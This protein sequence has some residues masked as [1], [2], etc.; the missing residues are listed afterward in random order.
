LK[1][2]YSNLNS[3]ELSA[4]SFIVVGIVLLGT[5]IFSSLDYKQ[6][7]IVARGFE[8]LDMGEEATATTETVKFVVNI[9]HEF[10]DQFYVAFTQVAV[11]PAETFEIPQTVFQTAFDEFINFAD[12]TAVAYA[13]QNSLERALVYAPMIAGTSVD[14]FT[15]QSEP[16]PKP[17]PD[18]G[19][20]PG[21]VI[22]YTYTELD[23]GL[24][25]KNIINMFD[26]RGL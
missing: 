8:I 1:T 14:L 11:L 26:I 5:I 3:F 19:P 25:T 15:Q 17:E 16:V 18:C 12:Q 9:P 23:I 7:T 6:Q 2:D 24:V 10:M 4:V 13:S 20:S 22:P 21:L